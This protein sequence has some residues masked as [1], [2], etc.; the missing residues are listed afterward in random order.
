[1]SIAAIKQKAAEGSFAKACMKCRSFNIKAFSPDDNDVFG[2]N[3]K[4]QCL[5][6]GSV[7]M[8]IELPV[9]QKK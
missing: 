7:G 9:K 4:Y 6:C 8:P 2:L 1:M 3:P 5:D